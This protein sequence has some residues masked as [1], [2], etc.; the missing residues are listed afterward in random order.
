VSILAPILFTAFEPSGD[1]HA[2]VVIAELQSR[3]PDMPIFAWGGPKMQA[4]GATIVERT[5]EDAVMGI[6]GASKIAEHIRMNRRIAAWMDQ[7]S[8]VLH[9]PVDSPGA[10]FP[11]CKLAK[12]RGIR[13][14]HLVAPQV[15]AW[16]TWRIK[17]LRRLTDFVLCLLPFEEEYFLSRGVP[18]K[19]V[20][21]PLF[22]EAL[23]VAALAEQARAYPT[24][25]PKIALMPGSRPSEMKSCFPILL[26]AFRRLRA[27]FKSAAGMVAAT[28]QETGQYLRD[29]AEEL[30]GWPEG[31]GLAT[32]QTD[33]V[34][35]WC[36]YAMTVSGT[37][38]LQIAK[39]GKPMVAMYRPSRLVVA[40][41]RT[42]MKLDRFTLPNLIAGRDLIPELIP[43]FGEGEEPAVEIIRLMR[44]TGYADDQ[45]E[46]VRQVVAKFEG[47]RA[48]E[49]A[50]DEIERM[51]GLRAPTTDSSPLLRISAL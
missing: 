7:H 1:D 13:V 24:G 35:H 11:V 25:T 5:G 45:R 23:D 50:A 33:A 20:G 6:P 31:L 41:G 36:D 34:I 10:N 30:G 12:A 17:K 48:G 44:Q 26:D 2:S 51:L 22:E 40:I 18:A 4:A 27:D 39:Q 8:P 14:V 15:W 38:T 16:A 9:V 43:P 21:H 28:K 19:F 42:L 32:G 37:V 47:R 49:L 3:H 46:G 29:Y